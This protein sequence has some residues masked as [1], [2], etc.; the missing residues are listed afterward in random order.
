MFIKEIYFP[1]GISFIIFS[2]LSY[3]LD[4]SFKE[5]PAEKNFL[6]FSNFILFFPKII[7]G[8]IWEFKAFREFYELPQMSLSG[9]VEGIKRFIVGLSKK[10]LIADSIG[11]VAQKVFAVDYGDLGFGLSWYG[12]IAF[13][14]QIYFDFSGYTDMAIGIGKIMGFNMPE[15]FNFPYFS[16]SIA[17]FWRRWHMTLTAWFRKYV[18]L[19]LEFQ[20]RKSKFFRQQISLVIVFFLTGLWH[21][22]SPNFIVWGVYFGILLA[23]ESLGWGDKLKK[24]PLVAQR[25]YSL[26]LILLGWVFFRITKIDQWVPFLKRSLALMVGQEWS[27]PEH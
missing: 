13:A 26:F 17:D 12:L 16:T 18:F 2:S 7:Q 21:G 6:T 9:S 1:L 4:V 14:L 5:I 24:L 3:L 20:N 19:P 25:F 8:P 15:N 27:I 22:V 10:V 11:M 23:L